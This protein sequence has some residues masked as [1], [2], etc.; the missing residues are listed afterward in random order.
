M[1]PSR[2][3]GAGKMVTESARGDFEAFG[4]FGVCFR[5]VGTSVCKCFI[6]YEIRVIHRRA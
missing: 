2:S 1:D 3:M 5:R 6:H 4:Y